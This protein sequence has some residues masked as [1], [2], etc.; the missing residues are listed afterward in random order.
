M[1]S[2][3]ETSGSMVLILDGNSLSSAHVICLNWY[4]ILPCCL[5]SKAMNFLSESK[6]LYDC[7]EVANEV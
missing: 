4:N 2:D 1:N 5:G 3:L 6:I 7:N